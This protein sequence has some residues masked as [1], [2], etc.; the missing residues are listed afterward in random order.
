M[1]PTGAGNYSFS[2]NFTELKTTSTGELILEDGLGFYKGKRVIVVDKYNP[3]RYRTLIVSADRKELLHDGHPGPFEASRFFTGFYDSSIFR[4]D[5][6][7]QLTIGALSRHEKDSKFVKGLGTIK[8]CDYHNEMKYYF[9]QSKALLAAGANPDLRNNYGDSPLTS[10]TLRATS[11]EK[12]PYCAELF[13]YLLNT[14]KVDPDGNAT[15]IWTP[16]HSA[17]LSGNPQYVQML[18]DA[19]ADP[20]GK[21]VGIHTP[22]YAAA[23]GSEPGLPVVS[24]LLEKGADPDAK[25]QGKETPLLHI[26]DHILKEKDNMLI[27][28][29]NAKKGLFEFTDKTAE[30]QKADEAEQKFRDLIDW[31]IVQVINP[32]A[33][34]GA[35][36]DANTE[37]KEETPRC[38][39]KKIGDEELNR[40]LD[41]MRT[42]FKNDKSLLK[43]KEE[44]SVDPYQASASRFP[45]LTFQTKRTFN[46]KTY[47]QLKT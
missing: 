2:S 11:P 28:K 40:C 42:Q 15:G 20:N 21:T 23:R 3:D 39:A 29:K 14:A 43:N 30:K 46:K 33:E 38:I 32:L 12:F 26:L 16:L 36:P 18:L 27:C 22:L 35:D 1:T 31:A 34:Y 19:G 25:A 13:E 44:E 7:L 17:A 6:P 10:L 4:E 47:Y 45:K 8:R 37:Q 24:L 41:E 5:T 9:N